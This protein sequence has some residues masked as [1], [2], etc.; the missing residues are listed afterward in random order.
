M[1]EQPTAM[2]VARIK[3]SHTG[4]QGRHREYESRLLRRTYREDGKVRHETLANLTKLPGHVVDAVEAAL[5]GDALTAARGA[6]AAVTITRSLPHGHVAAAWAMASNWG[7]RGC[8]ARPARSATSSSPWSSPASCSRARSCPPSPGGP[9]RYSAPTSASRRRRPTTCTRRWT[10]CGPGRTPIEATLARRHLAPAA[11]PQRMALFNLSSSWLE[12]T[13]CP[14]GERGYSRDGKKDSHAPLRG[15]AVADE[16]WVP[17]AAGGC[18]PWA[19]G[20]FAGDRVA[21]GGAEGAQ[22]VLACR[23]S[24]PFALDRSR[25]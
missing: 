25:P 5:K 15:S 11:N 17:R 8:S 18:G 14:L 21:A 7:S 16:N 12:G 13:H 4:K 1:L 9:A 20:V 24:S 2:H 10:G 22:L 3:S 23:P 19:A 6:P